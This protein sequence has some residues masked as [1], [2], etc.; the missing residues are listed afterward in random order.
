MGNGFYGFYGFNGLGGEPENGDIT[1]TQCFDID[2][3]YGERYTIRRYYSDKTIDNRRIELRA[4]NPA[5]KTIVLQLD[6]AYR[7]IGIFKCVL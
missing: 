1:L 6:K 7:T 2:Q 5:Y 4:L 3:D